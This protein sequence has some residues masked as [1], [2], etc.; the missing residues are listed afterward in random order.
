[1]KRRLIRFV[2]LLA[3]ILFCLLMLGTPAIF[4]YALEWLF[5]WTFVEPGGERN[6]RTAAFILSIPAWMFLLWFADRPMFR[7]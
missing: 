4:C 6:L 3:A 7:R 2:E 1:M 5:P